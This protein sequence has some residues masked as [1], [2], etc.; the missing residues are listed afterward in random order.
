MDVR[1]S[2]L[3]PLVLE[4]QAFVIDAETAKILA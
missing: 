4:R 1:E 2:M 3:A